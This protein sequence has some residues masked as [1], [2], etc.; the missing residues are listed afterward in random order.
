M[1]KVSV[2]PWTNM[3]DDEDDIFRLW[4]SNSLDASGPLLWKTSLIHSFWDKLRCTIP[5]SGL[6]SANCQ[7]LYILKHQTVNLV[8]KIFSKNFS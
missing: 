8:L 1:E 5:L 6:F 7:S 3:A 2:P 4:G